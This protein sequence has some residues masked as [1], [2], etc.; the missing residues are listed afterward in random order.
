MEAWDLRKERNICVHSS[1]TSLQGNDALI[2]KIK[3]VDTGEGSFWFIHIWLLV[4]LNNFQVQVIHILPLKIDN[5]K[6]NWHETQWES[7]PQR[8]KVP[9][10]TGPKMLLFSLYLDA[11]RVNYFGC[12]TLVP[13]V[14]VELGAKVRVLK[15]IL[16]I[17]QLGSNVVSVAS[18]QIALGRLHI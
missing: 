4:V 9:N 15:Y 11:F 17:D 1:V 14:L 2:L 16:K 18:I 12:W 8:Q 5:W 6:A 3:F 10:F 13:K 7:N